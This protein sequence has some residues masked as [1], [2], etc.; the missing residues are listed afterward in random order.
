MLEKIREG[1][2][3]PVAKI[4]LGAVI[5]SFALTGV[6][7][8]LGSNAEQMAAE[9]NGEEISRYDLDQAFQNE[10]QRMRSQLGEMFDTLAADSQYL[11]G[12]RQSVLDRMIAERLMDQKAEAM[13]LR[14]SDDQIRQAIAQM[15]E[16]QVDGRFDNDRYQAVL[17]QSGLTGNRLRDILRRD[18]AR[19]QLLVGLMGSEFT[20]EQEVYQLAQLQQQTRDARYA[21]VSAADFQQG[22]SVDEAAVEAFYQEN[23]TRFI[24]PEQVKVEYIELSVA[25]LAGTQE[26]SEQELQ[27]YYN[28]QSAQFTQPERRLAA[29]MLFEGDDAQARADEALARVRAGEAFADVAR[30]ASD[31]SFTAENG[32]ELD[33]MTPG[34]MD[35][36]FDE[37]LFGLEEGGV[38][39]VFASD[40]GYQIVQ[41]KA[42]EAATVLPFAEVKDNIAA[43]LQSDKA[44]REFYALQQTLADVSFEVPDSLQEAAD[45]VGLEVKTS[46][47][48]ERGLAPA[49]LN[50]PRALAAAFSDQ[51]LLD[52]MNSDLVE[53]D[54][55]HM[56]VL[57]VLEHVEE[58]TQP[59]A[60]VRDQI[61]ERLTIDQ[62]SEQAQSQAD[63]LLNA[64]QGGEAPA[65]VIELDAV[66]RMGQAELDPA[67]TQQL[68]KM[69]LT[70]EGST[71]ESVR[72]PSGDIAVV[73]L[74]AIHTPEAVDG[75]ELLKSRLSQQMSEASYQA[76]IDSLRADAKI[77]YQA[78][79]VQ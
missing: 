6:Y 55:G 58:G 63:A 24:Q 3:G 70:G 33:W 46:P 41:A 42:V 59:L 26:V 74:D 71:I 4:I 53:I 37:A 29:H 45:A 66:G 61:V 67:L 14:V 18:M 22:I 60:D 13:G 76:L 57:R 32:G 39:D 31:D 20:T 17:R 64:W 19:Q 21:L 9:V 48:F 68:F 49:P 10:Q 51:V 77:L 79:A 40:F 78:G 28:G 47:L 73:A 44:Q 5:L 72:L 50:H 52:Q 12:L 56:L 36:A 1:S 38:S 16:F 15:P 23:P 35:V 54:N 25:D 2:Q 62:A 27:E 34:A 7:S 11:A 75:E 30:E 65:E 8:Y 69:A 43:T